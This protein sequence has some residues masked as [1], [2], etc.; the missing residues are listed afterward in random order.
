LWKPIKKFESRGAVW[1]GRCGD[2]WNFIVRSTIQLSTETTFLNTAPLLEEKRDIPRSA[3]FSYFQHPL[4]THWP[5]ARP[6][7]SA[8]DYPVN[9]A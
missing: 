9:R 5:R 8:N 7:F 4:F 2:L 3:L 6:A 1:T